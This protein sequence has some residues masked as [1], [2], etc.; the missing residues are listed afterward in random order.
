MFRVVGDL[1]I[2][3]H[4]HEIALA[5]VVQGAGEDPWGNERVGLQARAVINRTE[6]GLTWQQRVARGGVLVG[7]AVTLVLDVSAVRVQA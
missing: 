4:T 1:T 7:D 2:G 5:T 3:D 6:F